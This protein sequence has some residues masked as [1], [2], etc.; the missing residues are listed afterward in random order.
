MKLT[1]IFTAFVF[2]TL[3]TLCCGA[4]PVTEKQPV[5]DTYHGVEVVDDYRWLEDWNDERVK[6]WSEMQNRNAREVLDNVVSDD[7]IVIDLDP[8]NDTVVRLLLREPASQQN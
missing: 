1:Q 3:T 8:A 4:P 2:L 7:V 6:R 5:M